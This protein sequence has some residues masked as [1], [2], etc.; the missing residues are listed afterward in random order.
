M[1]LGFIIKS[2][3]LISSSFFLHC[4]ESLCELPIIFELN[5]RYYMSSDKISQHDRYNDV[6]VFDLNKVFM[7]FLNPARV[8]KFENMQI[9]GEFIEDNIKGK[10]LKFPKCYFVQDL[11]TFIRKI[12]DNEI[13]ANEKVD[14]ELLEQL[15]NH[16][17]DGTKVTIKKT[18]AQKDNV[19]IFFTLEIENSNDNVVES[20]CCSSCKGGKKA[21]ENKDNS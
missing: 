10:K 2:L 5:T 12:K 18:A 3:F 20:K 11:G 8:I 19:A 7:D 17:F 13:K 4:S 9:S 16:S 1:K 6:V 14:P 15:P 21:E